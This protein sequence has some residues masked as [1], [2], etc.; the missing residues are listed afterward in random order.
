MRYRKQ[1]RAGPIVSELRLGTN[2]F[3]EVT[4]SADSS[5]CRQPAVGEALHGIHITSRVR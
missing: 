2:V 3:G 4:R 1:G 5:A